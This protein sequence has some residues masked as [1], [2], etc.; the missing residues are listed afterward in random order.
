MAILAV[1]LGWFVDRRQLEA[2]LQRAEE[3]EAVAKHFK[4]GGDP[5]EPLLNRQLRALQK[6]SGTN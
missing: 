5:Y 1:A 2:R 6:K 4:A 3:A